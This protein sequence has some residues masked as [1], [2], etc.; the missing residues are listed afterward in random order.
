MR[1]TILI[2]K[3]SFSQSNDFKRIENEID[4]A[5]FSI[6]NPEGSGKFYLFDEKKR[7]GVVPIKIS[8]IEKLNALGWKD[9][10]TEDNKEFQK[11]RIDTALKLPNG[12]FFGVEWETG[13]IS[14]SHRALNRLTKGIMD[15]VLSGGFLV[16][17]SRKMYNYLTDRVGNYQELEQYFDIWRAISNV[18]DDA[19]LGVIEI[20]HDGVSKDIN[21]FQKGTDGRAKV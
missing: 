10:K 19:V 16:L 3:G 17:P 12:K 20:E 21:P 11:R 6:Q 13:N 7:N 14:S 5:I 1:K 18:I 15:G 2:S 4:T 9:E 8:F